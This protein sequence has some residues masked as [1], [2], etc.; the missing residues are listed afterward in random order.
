MPRTK[1]VELASIIYEHTQKIDTYLTSQNLPTPS[2]NSAYPPKLSLP[3]GIQNGQEA[4]LEASDEITALMLG[5]AGCIAHQSVR[6]SISRFSCI[7]DLKMSIAQC[8]DNCP[9][10]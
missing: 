8:M 6:A 3:L 4:V 9:S 5:P 7:S 1:I 10:H 2:F